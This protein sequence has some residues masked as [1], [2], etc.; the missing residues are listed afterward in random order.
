MWMTSDLYKIQVASVLNDANV[1]PCEDF[2]EAMLP[3]LEKLVQE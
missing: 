1:D 2:L 3:E